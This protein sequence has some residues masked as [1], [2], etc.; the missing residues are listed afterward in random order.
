[1]IIY[2]IITFFSYIG[3]FLCEIWNSLPPK[4][5]E[6]LRQLLVEEFG[7]SEE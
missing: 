3:H 5:V 2:F 1:M 4:M 7:M 6:Q